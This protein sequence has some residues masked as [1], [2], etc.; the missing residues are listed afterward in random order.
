MQICYWASLCLYFLPSIPLWLSLVI[1][2]SISSPLFLSHTKVRIRL[3]LNS[4][5]TIIGTTIQII[6]Q[7]VR[8]LC[9]CDERKGKL[10]LQVW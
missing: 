4:C 9:M 2:V 8:V 3:S 10:L 5:T 1:L 7:T 6:Q